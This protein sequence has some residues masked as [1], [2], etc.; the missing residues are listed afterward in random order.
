M[1]MRTLTRSWLSSATRC[2]LSLSM[3]VSL[4]ACD[5]IPGFGGGDDSPN[6]KE[7]PKGHKMI[8]KINDMSYTAEPPDL[9]DI[10]DQSVEGLVSGEPASVERLDCYFES[11]DEGDEIVTFSF[12]MEGNQT[13]RLQ[14][15][16]GEGS[17]YQLSSEDS[18][19]IDSI[20]SIDDGSETRDIGGEWSLTM[21]YDKQENDNGPAVIKGKVYLAVG[22]DAE[23]G[24]SMLVGTFETNNI[25]G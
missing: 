14:L 10:S 16:T 12:S 15:P 20:G 17:S 24:A 9:D 22:G 6:Q 25:M 2:L 1:H 8:P 11:N 23:G 4:V 19:D 18:R 21:K 13:I 5:Q 7:E 3:V